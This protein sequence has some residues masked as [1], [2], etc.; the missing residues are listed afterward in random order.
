MIGLSASASPFK[1]TYGVDIDI[2]IAIYNDGVPSMIL[3]SEEDVYNVLQGI[4]DPLESFPPDAQDAAELEAVEAFVECM[5]NY[6]LMEEREE[7]MR[8]DFTHIK[9]RWEARRQEGLV[10]RPKPA[11]PETMAHAHMVKCASP[12]NQEMRDLVR[13]YIVRDVKMADTQRHKVDSRTKGRVGKMIHQNKT[14]LPIQQPKKQ[15]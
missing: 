12:H 3:T 13:S 2:D 10:G 6:A 9:K 8:N 15:Y 5:A 14:R 4:E 11:K 1:P 7:R